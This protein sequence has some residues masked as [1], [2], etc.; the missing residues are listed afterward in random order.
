MDLDLTDPGLLLR[1]DVLDDPRPLYDELRRAA[2]VWRVPGQDT[3]VVTDPALIRDVVARP[4]ELSSNLVSLLHSD[5][6]GGLVPFPIAPLGDPIHVLATAD[7]PV[8]TRHRRVLQPHLSPSAVADLAPTLHRIVDRHLT[9]LLADGAGD[10]V[11]GFA[12]PVP[13]EAI[14]AVIGLPADD[15]PRLLTLVA[16]TGPLLDGVTDLEGM[17]RAGAAALALAQYTQ[18]QVEAAVADRAQDAAGLLRVFADAIATGAVGVAEVR[19]IL[20]VL[21]NA[22]AETTS[23][24]I[25]AAAEILARDSELQGDLRKWPDR[26]PAALEDVLRDDAPFQFHYRWTTRD[27]ELGSV[28]VPAGSRVL[29]MWAAANRP[30]PGD[31]AEAAGAPEARGQAP[32]YAFGRGLHFC[33]GAHLAR[34]EAR[35]A[36]EQLLGRTSSIALDPDRPPAMRPSIFLRRH[37]SL[38]IVLREA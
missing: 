23:S 6:A 11:A 31:G 16:E 18:S 2:P 38:P 26:I 35:I 33:I 20:V 21:V 27:T 22:G 17:H 4:A 37:A 30:A 15:A 32:H 9:P 25:A 28:A 19:D 13:M 36:L 29:L 10:L 24:L 8:H 5:E 34:L 3:Y 12:N 14:C 7:A 1:P